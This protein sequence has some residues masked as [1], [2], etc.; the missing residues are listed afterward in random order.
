MKT[1]AINEPMKFLKRLEIDAKSTYDAETKE[2]QAAFRVGLHDGFLRELE[3]KKPTA[4]E[5]IIET[6]KIK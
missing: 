4:L 3:T 1:P 2:H 6:G 5:A